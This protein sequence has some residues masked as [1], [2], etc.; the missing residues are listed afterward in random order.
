MK[1][2][3]ICIAFSAVLAV[4][5]SCGKF[6]DEPTPDITIPEITTTA[7]TEITTQTRN[8]LTTAVKSDVPKIKKMSDS[9]KNKKEDIIVTPLVETTP[10]NY[11][12]ERI[13][14]SI[15]Y[16]TVVTPVNTIVTHATVTTTAVSSSTVT[17]TTTVKAENKPSEFSDIEGKWVYQERISNHQYVSAGYVIIQNDGSFEFSTDESEIIRYGKVSAEIGTYLDGTEFQNYIFTDKEYY[18]MDCHFI[19]DTKDILFVN[20][21]ESARLIR[22]DSFSNSIELNAIVGDWEYQ[23]RDRSK[24]EYK[25]LGR[26]TIDCLGN[27]TYLPYDDSDKKSGMIAL[28]SEKYSD[29]KEKYYYAFCEDGN[30]DNIWKSCFCE[31]ADSDIYYAGN[32]GDSRFVRISEYENGYD[33]SML[34]YHWEYQYLT[35]HDDGFLHYDT[36]GYLDIE[37]DGHYTYAS[38]DGKEKRYGMIKPEINDEGLAVFAFYDYG[39]YFWTYCLCEQQELDRIYMD[40][41]S[42]KIRIRCYDMK[43]TSS[44]RFNGVWGEDNFVI[45]VIKYND[46]FVVKILNGDGKNDLS[47]HYNCEYDEKEDILVCMKKGVKERIRRYLNENNEYVSINDLLADECSAKFRIDGDDIIWEDITDNKKTKCSP[48]DS[49]G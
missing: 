39:Q 27:Y 40:A 18:I 23:E 45:S 31:Q 20:F 35:L 13:S 22:E 38:L 10:V 16:E 47:W 11:D 49:F 12:T 33:I 28:K 29:G 5:T 1:K 7:T 37:D 14:D 43:K 24:D 17:A 4:M 19:A 6:D 36:V 41:Y 30:Y 25:T 42:D 21:N 34:A 26:L 9:R 46:I 32:G 3:I 2:I 15:T 44:D 48:L 8:T